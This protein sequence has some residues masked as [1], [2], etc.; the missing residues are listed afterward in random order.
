M[1]SLT[2]SL[3]NSEKC[4]IEGVGA[5]V[6]LNMLAVWQ[7]DCLLQAEVCSVSLNSVAT[8]FKKL[9]DVFGT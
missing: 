1:Q 2:N 8:V 9:R 5:K 7:T 3:P 6:A 4:W